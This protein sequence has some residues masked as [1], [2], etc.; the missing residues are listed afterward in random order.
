MARCSNG[1]VLHAV[2]CSREH[3]LWGVVLGPKCSSCAVLWHVALDSMVLP[4]ARYSD[5]WHFY[6]MVLCWCNA[7]RRAIAPNVLMSLS[8]LWLV[9][10]S[11]QCSSWLYPK[12]CCA[13]TV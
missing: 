2:Q 10:P 9:T 6:W 4:V 1:L 13:P 7:L 11:N 5:G 12:W 3:G 8:S